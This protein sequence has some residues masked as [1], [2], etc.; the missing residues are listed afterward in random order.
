LTNLGC[1]E[2]RRKINERRPIKITA[3]NNS[4]VISAGQTIT[5]AHIEVEMQSVTYSP[6]TQ[7]YGEPLLSNNFII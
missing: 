2:D 6:I 3:R 5:I 7:S 1:R 4:V